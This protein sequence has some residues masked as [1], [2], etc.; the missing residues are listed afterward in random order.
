VRHN[1]NDVLGSVCPRESADCLCSFLSVYPE[2]KNPTSEFNKEMKQVLGRSVR[3]T[4][5]FKR[6]GPVSGKKVKKY[7]PQRLKEVR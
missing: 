4:D 7:I 5:A 6:L 2:T 3:I 1:E